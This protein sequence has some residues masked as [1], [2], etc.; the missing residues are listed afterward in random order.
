MSSVNFVLSAFES[1]FSAAAATIP[2]QQL[3]LSTNATLTL[4][5]SVSKAAI[6]NTFFFRTDQPITTDA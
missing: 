5:T 4:S 6:Q 3:D 2:S 1:S